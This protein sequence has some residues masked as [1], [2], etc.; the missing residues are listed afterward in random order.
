M[1][2]CIHG[3]EAGSC[4]LC[5][6]TIR[7]EPPRVAAAGSTGTR[8]AAPKRDITPKRLVDVNVQRLFHV[9]HVRN[10][11]AI[12]EAE[13]LV[14]GVDPE[15]DLSSAVT[16]ELRRSA[17]ATP[18]RS[19][20]QHV[21]FYLTPDAERW[22]ALRE[23]A[24]GSTWSRAARSASPSDFIALVATWAD[25]T[26]AVVADDDAAGSRTRFEP[27]EGLLRRVLRDE[28][29]LPRAEVLVPDRVPLS[30]ISIVGVANIKVR[31]TVRELWDDWRVMVYP[32]WFLV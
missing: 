10:L 2:E 1:P 7:L 26:D 21:P 25:L 28:E 3:L 12:V 18:G 22:T 24:K 9:T 19:V 6:P 29:R 4:D 31:D 11:P 17:E 32:P 20:A 23:G 5:N 13:A 14:A 8:R 15:V 16:R 30:A 27:G